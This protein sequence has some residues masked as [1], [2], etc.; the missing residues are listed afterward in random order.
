MKYKLKTEPTS[1]LGNVQV[2]HFHP[3][4]GHFGRMFTQINLDGGFIGRVSY[5]TTFGARTN[6]N[7]KAILYHPS[8]DKPQDRNH[9]MAL[10]DK[11]EAAGKDVPSKQYLDHLANGLRF[12][13]K[14]S[15]TLYVN[16]STQDMCG[17]AAKYLQQYTPDD[18]LN[19]HFIWNKILENHAGI[20]KAEREID[21]DTY[22]A[23]TEEQDSLLK[24]FSDVTQNPAIL[25]GFSFSF[26]E[27]DFETACS[28]LCRFAGSNTIGFCEEYVPPLPKMPILD[29]WEVDI[30]EI[31]EGL[32]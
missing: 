23:L 17:I 15:G 27:S 25:P 28:T 12:E 31:K 4:R 22:K 10:I 11:L 18:I 8:Y 21:V 32:R 1:S 9:F 7:Y 14:P 13:T 2:Y 16:T 19:P 24:E 26:V 20:S 3:L 6:Y 5:P 29:P 30:P